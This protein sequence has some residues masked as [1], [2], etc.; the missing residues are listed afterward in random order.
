M[1]IIFFAKSGNQRFGNFKEVCLLITFFLVGM[2]TTNA[3][4]YDTHKPWAYWWWMGSAVDEAGI[5]KNLQDYAQAGFGGLHIIP[6][7]GVKGNDANNIDFLSPK[8]NQM[9]AFTVKE[10][11]NLGLGI[12]MTMG[13]GWPF[14]GKQVSEKDAAKT[15]EIVSENGKNSVKVL[16]TKQKVKRAAPGGEGFVLD[17]FSKEA[18]DHYMKPFQTLFQSSE[19]GVRALYNDS[20]EV[21]GANW[22]D[23]FL[24]EFQ[25]R[26]GYDL[27][28]Y[29]NVLA[30]TETKDLLEKRIFGD[31]NATIA[32]LCREAFT[33]TWADGVKKMGKISRN[34]AHGSP[35]NMLDLYALS[36]VPE[37]EYFG[38]KYFD[39][40]YFRRDPKFEEARYGVPDPLVIKFASSAA[41]TENKKFVGSETATWL[42]DHFKVSLSQVKPIIDESLTSGINHIFYHGVPYS[43]PQEAYP[44]WLFYASTNFNQQSHFWNELHFLNEYIARC[45]ARLQESKAQ[46]DVLLYFPIHDIWHDAGGKDHV[47]LL[48]VHANA[49]ELLFNNS[50]GQVAKLLQSKGFNFDYVSD[51]QLT[52]LKYVNGKLQSHGGLTYKTIVIPKTQYLP[53]ETLKALQALQK[54]GAPILF[55]DQLPAN[56]AG[57]KNWESNEAFLANFNKNLKATEISVLPNAL[58]KLGITS[59]EMANKGISF[60]KKQNAKGTL[61]FISNFSQQFQEGKVLLG[62]KGEAVEIYDP[63]HQTKQYIPFSKKGAYTEIKLALLAGE[64]R[65]IQFFDK[66]PAQAI[67]QNTTA[68]LTHKVEING[69]WKVDF[70]EGQ[71]FLPKSYQTTS[72]GSWTSV[73]DST[74]QYFTGTAKYSIDFDWKS[75]KEN[76]IYLNLGN[77]RESAKV[78]LNGQ[79]LG[80]LW[81]LPFQV[82]IPVKLLKEKN[83]LEIEVKNLSANRM[84]YI[85]KQSHNWK[86]FKDINIV[87][88]QYKALEP[89]TWEAEPSGLL[90]HVQILY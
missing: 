62:A 57:F 43:P 55:V 71:P 15:F 39:I 25:K 35:G 84:R 52:Q 86:K 64:S 38:T 9:L 61:Y 36:D 76:V 75:V 12:D 41:N 46:N 50:F 56:T 8:W 14:G 33:K 10:A 53:T 68:Q 5:R 78:T 85:D 80:T 28:P 44:G 13:T 37:T 45:Q 3:Q 60:I 67:A 58:A 29:L 18:L 81:S 70:L 72:L 30:K 90:G 4:K 20:Y 83:H 24:E 51:L 2:F 89:S 79:S 65:F 74:N 82:A 23:N 69:T 73:G 19:Y 7:Y 42:A 63:L 1:K 40:P 17:H 59:E 11:K 34:E 6:I 54:Q 77:V 27:T 32:D 49:Q 48:S 88:I 87:D 16:P 31:Y 66:K 21:Y 22:T 47:H 26:R